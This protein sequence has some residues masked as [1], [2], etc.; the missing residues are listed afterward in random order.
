MK[1]NLPLMIV[2]VLFFIFTS[3][4]NSPVRSGGEG[5]RDKN[6][7]AGK[8]R[9]KEASEQTQVSSGHWIAGKKT[10]IQKAKGVRPEVDAVIST[11]LLRYGASV[12]ETPP[13]DYIIEVGGS[14]TRNL[15]VANI[16][17]F[18]SNRKL[19]AIGTGESRISSERYGFYAYY[20]NDELD[21]AAMKSAVTMAVRGAMGR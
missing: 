13:A 21:Y 10:V 19:L 16:K 20:S 6:P 9:K 8:I 4:A 17:V 12:V 5:A 3:C 14:Q 1:K 7:E 15:A 2:F 18:D 11:E